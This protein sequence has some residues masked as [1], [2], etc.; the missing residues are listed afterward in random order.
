MTMRDLR[1]NYVRKALNRDDLATDPIEQFQR[2]FLEAV[3]VDH[4]EW[5]E[6]NAM[7]LA[8]YELQ[9][10]QVYARIVL[11]KHFDASGFTFFSNYNS[12]KGLQL[13]AHPKASLALYWPHTEQQVRIQGAVSRTDRET[14]ER[15][16]HARPRA[17]QLGAAASPQSKAIPDRRV[18]EAEVERLDQL[19]QDREIPCPEHW[20]GYLLTPHEIEFWQ[21][22]SDRLHDRFVYRLTDATPQPSWTIQRLSP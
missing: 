7:T 20:G 8:T 15:Y 11:L 17:S 14:S 6:L 12:D 22:R 5:L 13:A 1:R 18:L 10:G 4:P 19:Y 3:A 16:F 2:W 21:G 9:S